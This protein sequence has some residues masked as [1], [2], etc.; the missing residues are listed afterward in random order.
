MVI[1]EKSKFPLGLIAFMLVIFLGNFT[2]SLNP[3]YL[4]IFGESKEGT[5]SHYET[6]QVSSGKNSLR[7]H[8]IPVVE[9]V[10]N[11]T[12]YEVP[13]ML[14]STP[15]EGN[16]IREKVT[17]KYIDKNPN[18]T[19]Y[20]KLQNVTID[21]SYYKLYFFKD[22]LSALGFISLI[23][24]FYLAFTEP[25]NKKTILL[26]LSTFPISV[27]CILWFIIQY[28]L[29]SKGLVVDKNPI[30]LATAAL[31]GSAYLVFGSKALV[32][33]IKDLFRKKSLRKMKE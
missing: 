26:L 33:L 30:N 25:S 27:C 32:L 5:I 11:G 19:I 23:A 6:V 17:L 13:I 7:T 22:F 24:I 21:S 8:F 4:S 28:I 12:T 10:E 14:N 3:I 16:L 15:A 29:Y 31:I 2:K 9:I 1:M 18:G 20:E